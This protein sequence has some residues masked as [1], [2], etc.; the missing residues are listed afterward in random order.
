MGAEARGFALDIPTNPSGFEILG[1]KKQIRHLKEDIRDL[2]R[3]KEVMDEFP[4]EIVFHLAAQALVGGSFDD[5]GKT[6]KTNTLGPLNVL[7][8]VTHR[9]LFLAFLL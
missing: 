1:L 7:S 8:C 2:N 3:L 9:A 6:F 4:P 5:P